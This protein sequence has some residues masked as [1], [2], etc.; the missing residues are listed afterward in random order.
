MA[1]PHKCRRVHWHPEYTYFKPQGIPI[2][3]LDEVNLTVDEF[4]AIRLADLEGLYQEQAAEKMGVSRQT[5]GNIISAAHLKIADSLV[6]GKAVKIT[7]GMYE[8][9]G[10]RAF[11]CAH[12]A[13]EWELDFGTGRP[14]KCPQC[15]GSDFQRMILAGAEEHKSQS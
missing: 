9:E 8:M 11:H 7:G 1:R 5:F 6:N 3:A 13:H 4:E 14:E 12:C 10:K 15:R 2:R